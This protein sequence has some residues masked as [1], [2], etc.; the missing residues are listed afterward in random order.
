MFSLL[1]HLPQVVVNTFP[2]CFVN[3][4]ADVT[5]LQKWVELNCPIA[6]QETN[7]VFPDPRQI[8]VQSIVTAN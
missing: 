7:S 8:H 2:N 1:I 5:S 3:T 6:A 4:Q